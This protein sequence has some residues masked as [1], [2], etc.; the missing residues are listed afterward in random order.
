MSF[1]YQNKP[2]PNAVFTSYY[3]P[4]YFLGAAKIPGFPHVQNSKYIEDEIDNILK[5]GMKDYKDFARVMA[6][7]IGKIKHA[8]SEKARKF[9]YASDWVDCET[10]N[11]KRFGKVFD[12]KSFWNYINNNQTNLSNLCTSNPQAALNHLANNSPD[13]IGS[14]YLITI[15]F[16]LSHGK[17]PIYDRFAAASLIANEKNI[18]PCQKEQLSLPVI[19][20]KNSAEFNNIYRKIYAPYIKQLDLQFPNWQNN[21][22]VDRALWVYGHGL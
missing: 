15:L 20:D 11:P 10:Q 1:Y 9:V 16:F 14:V 8:E 19:P 12:L 4:A 6:W 7:K 2:I 18:K 22:D 5:N 21:R 3:A 13:G 17:L